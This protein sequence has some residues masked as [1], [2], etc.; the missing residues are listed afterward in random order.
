MT[1][2]QQALPCRKLPCKFAYYQ[3]IWLLK[4]LIKVKINCSKPITVALLF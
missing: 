3:I 4:Q 2:L 1:G